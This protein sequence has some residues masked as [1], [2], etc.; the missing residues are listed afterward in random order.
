ML[1][2]NKCILLH[3]LRNT[4]LTPSCLHNTHSQAKVANRVQPP[5]PL[6]SGSGDDEFIL[7][8]D[9]KMIRSY[10]SAMNK[11]V[12]QAG[13]TKVLTATCDG[14]GCNYK[15][16]CWDMTVQHEDKCTLV[17]TSI[18]V[19]SLPKAD[20]PSN[21]CSLSTCENRVSN[22]FNPAKKKRGTLTGPMCRYCIYCIHFRRVV[23]RDG[24]YM[25][26]N[27][28]DPKDWIEW[29]FPSS[30]KPLLSN[31]PTKVPSWMSIDPIYAITDGRD[32]FLQAAEVIDGH[33]NI[34]KAGAVKNYKA[35]NNSSQHCSGEGC[36]KRKTP[37]ISHKMWCS[38]GAVVRGHSNDQFS[39]D[40]VEIETFCVEHALE[41]GRAVVDENNDI[42]NVS[43]FIHL[44]CVNALIIFGSSNISISL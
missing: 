13:R 35:P 30:Y 24:K 31:T 43:I 17:S 21:K 39:D 1:L 2:V 10:G 18:K 4:Y 19:A 36:E 20:R 25:L 16:T 14:E 26:Q 33:R 9:G 44:S 34:K 38:V 28:G 32:T 7:T 22:S 40:L 23:Y 29:P 15:S 6:E 5:S 41:R 12:F 8:P 37:E 3:T 11:K 27:P 42:V